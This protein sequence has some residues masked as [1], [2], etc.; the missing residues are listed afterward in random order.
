VPISQITAVDF[1]TLKIAS[2]PPTETI[3]LTD[4][5]FSAYLAQ[6]LDAQDQ[7]A[8]IDQRGGEFAMSDDPAPYRRDPVSTVPAESGHL[9]TI[10]TVRMAAAK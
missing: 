5:G 4:D 1:S 3:S 9:N 7:R 6:I 2:N 10:A 8:S